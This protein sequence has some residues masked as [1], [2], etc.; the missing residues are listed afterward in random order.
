MLHYRSK[1]SIAEIHTLKVPQKDSLIS[2]EFCLLRKIF[3]EM[4][5]WLSPTP[6]P[7][8]GAAEAALAPPGR[9]ASGPVASPALSQA[10]NGSYRRCASVRVLARCQGFISNCLVWV[11]EAQVL[12]GG[13]E[14]PRGDFAGRP[15]AAGV[16]QTE[17]SAASLHHHQTPSSAHCGLGNAKKSWGGQKD[18]YQTELLRKRFSSRLLTPLKPTPYAGRNQTSQL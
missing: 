3:N 7:Q 5:L 17:C 12:Q 4:S 2:T 15:A 14:S 6:G 9:A 13:L 16:I 11:C 8:A 18:P 10:T 1:K